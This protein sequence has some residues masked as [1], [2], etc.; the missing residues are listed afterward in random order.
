M[1]RELWGGGSDTKC[2]RDVWNAELGVSVTGC[3]QG[4]F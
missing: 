4:S 3:L 1:G 2:G